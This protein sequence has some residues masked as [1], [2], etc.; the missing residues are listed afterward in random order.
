MNDPHSTQAKKQYTLSPEVNYRR[1]GSG[2]RLSDRLSDPNMQSHKLIKGWQRTRRRCPR[3]SFKPLQLRACRKAPEDLV[4]MSISS[5]SNTFLS[6]TQFLFQE[7]AFQ[8]TREIRKRRPISNGNLPVL[9]GGTAE[10]TPQEVRSHHQ[11][12][13]IR[14]K[15][16][17][18][19]KDHDVR[20]DHEHA[21]ELGTLTSASNIQKWQKMSTYPDLVV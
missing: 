7:S 13:D 9:P 5:T 11:S 20:I 14:R 15:S 6:R 3:S 1:V 21:R 17:Q 12:Q 2:D 19:R 18:K 8:I 16:L 10:K 4:T